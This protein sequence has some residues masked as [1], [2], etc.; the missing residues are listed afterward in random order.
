[1][2]D[3]ITFRVRRLYAAI[4]ANI[5]TDL[6]KFPATVTVNDKFTYV[7][8]NFRG[9]WTEEQIHNNAIQ[10][11]HA[12]ANLRDNL[13]RWAAANGKDRQRVWDTFNNSFHIRVIMDLSNVEKHGYPLTKPSSSGRDPKL[14]DV[15]RRMV[16]PPGTGVAIG[17]GTNGVPQQFGDGS[18]SV[19]V[20]GVVAD[21]HGTVI[22]HLHDI[23]SKAVR[24]WE[25]LLAE[26]G[27]RLPDANS[28]AA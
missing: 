1:V 10:V 22:G 26:F 3:D 14:V 18:T 5:E 21:K 12:I 9:G 2:S 16:L 19:V 20:T 7:E 6:T 28:T 24:D 4:G 23:E 11:I 8:Q 25:A 15:G 27:L 17:L 13:S